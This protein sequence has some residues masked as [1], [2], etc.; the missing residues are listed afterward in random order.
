MSCSYYN[1]CGDV[2][3]ITVTQ[4][5]HNKNH[6]TKDTSELNKNHL[7]LLIYN[8]FL[9]STKNHTVHT[10]C[11]ISQDKQVIHTSMSIANQAH[12]LS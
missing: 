7:T 6:M 1:G 4:I 3:Q 9:K 2:R 10:K 11:S 8:N 5:C 12:N